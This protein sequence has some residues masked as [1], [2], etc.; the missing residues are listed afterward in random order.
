MIWPRQIHRLK[1]PKLYF[2]IID[3]HRKRSR[4]GRFLHCRRYSFLRCPPVAAPLFAPQ[5]P[6][7]PLNP[8]AQSPLFR[9]HS[10]CPAF[11]P[12]VTAPSFAPQR[13][14]PPLNPRAFQ[15]FPAPR[16]AITQACGLNIQKFEFFY[17]N[18]CQ[19]LVCCAIIWVQGQL[20]HYEA[21][22]RPQ[23]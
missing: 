16:L 19:I 22:S 12:P 1:L 9:P 21:P 10:C 3:N 13:P 7:H 5:R 18:G 14:P 11:L 20:S 15:I 8:R 4:R 17:K 23:D 2:K 6:P